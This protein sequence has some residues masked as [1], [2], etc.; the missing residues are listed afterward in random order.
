MAYFLTGILAGK[1]GRKPLFYIFSILMPI[2][3]MLLYFGGQMTPNNFL[4]VV[5]GIVCGNVVHDAFQVLIRIVVF[6]VVPTDKRGRGS[7]SI[8]FTHS[9]GITLGFMIGSILTLFFELGMAFILLSLPLL[10]NTI[11][12]FKFLKETMDTNLS[13]INK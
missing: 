8:I 11:F 2:G 5:L 12:I 7:K 13:L 9:L 10:L 1:F 6:K 3:R 4:I